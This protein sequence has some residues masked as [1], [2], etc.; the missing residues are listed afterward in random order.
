MKNKIIEI[1]KSE[2][3]IFLLV[4]GFNTFFGYLNFAIFQYLWGKEITYIGSLLLSHIV[5]STLAFILYRRFVFKVSGNTIIDFFRFQ[6]VYVFPLIT[7]LFLLPLAVQLF[8][9][10]PYF[11]QAIVTICMTAVSY[12]G[13]KYFS[14]KRKK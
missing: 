10:N 7:N 8:R 6:S 14:F 4:G 11:A 9:M 3:F 13:H 12:I 1:L 2:Q 5:T